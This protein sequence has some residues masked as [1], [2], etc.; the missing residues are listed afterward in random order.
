[1]NLRRALFLSLLMCA[2]YG[3][4]DD[5]DKKQDDC[6]DGKC[7]MP[8][9]DESCS[10]E[11]CGNDAIDGDEACDGN[12]FANGV[13][14][15]AA[16][17]ATKYESGNLKCTSCAIDTSDCV[18]KT[19]TDKCG[20]ET[21]DD[22]EACDGNKFANDVTSCAAYDATKYESGN[23]KCSSCAIDTSDC[24]EIRN[25]SASCGNDT[26]D[27]GEACDGNKFVNDKSACAD[28]DAKYISG[29]AKCVDCA[30]DLSECKEPTPECGDGI[31]NQDSEECDKNSFA[32]DKSM[33]SDI[34]DAYASGALKC[35]DE[36]K[37]IKDDCVQKPLD[38]PEGCG[39]KSL[40]ED[41]WCDGDQFMEGA[42]TC[43]AWIPGSKG[44]VSCMD[45][46]EV[47][48]G[49][50][51]APRCGDGVINQPD[52]FC[53]I[54]A[55]ADG[56]TWNCKDWSSI[57][58]DGKL[59]CNSK[60]VFDESACVQN[61]GNGKLDAGEWCDASASDP[62]DPA[63]NTCSK[64]LGD[65]KYKGTLQCN[66]CKVDTSKCYADETVDPFCGDGIIN[67]DDEKCDTNAFPN[68]SNKCE[69]Y[70]TIYSGG[71]LSCTKNCRLD[72]S[73][74]E[75]APV[76]LCGNGKIDEGEDCDNTT[77]PGGIIKCSKYDPKYESGKL[78][79][80]NLCHIDT[81]A[82][83][84]R[85]DPCGN[86]KLDEGELCDDKLFSNTNTLCSAWGNYA[87]GNV[88][89]TATCEISFA[90]CVAPSTEKEPK[91][92]DGIVNQDSEQCDY[93]DFPLGN[94]RCVN[95]KEMTGKNYVSGSVSCN[96]C[97]LD[98]SDCVEVKCGDGVIN[99]DDEWC[100]KD[101]FLGDASN[102]V[103]WGDYAGGKVSCNND[104]TLNLSA[105]VAKPSAKCGDGIINQ[106][107]EECDGSAFLF[108]ENTCNGWDSQ[109]I[110]GNVTCNTKT[111][112][113]EYG[114]CKTAADYCGNGKIDDNAGEWCDGTGDSAVFYD[115]LNSCD[116]YDANTKGALKC[117]NCVLDTSA[118]V[119]DGCESGAVRCD[120]N[121]LQM[122]DDHGNWY[123]MDKCSG[124][125][126]V[127][128]VNDKQDD[129]KCVANPNP[130]APVDWCDFQYL[131]P[132]TH[133]G[134]ARILFNDQIKA[135]DVEVAMFCTSDLDKPVLS[136]NEEIDANINASCDNCGNNTEFMTVKGAHGDLGKN[137]CTMIYLDGDNF[138][139]CK[140]ITDG[141]S[142][143]I[144]ITETTKLS[145]S[146]V[147]TFE[148][149]ATCADGSARCNGASY[150]ECEN[151]EWIPLDD[152]PTGKVCS[153]ADGLFACVDQLSSYDITETFDGVD[154]KVWNTASSYTNKVENINYG[155]AG[156]MTTISAVYN[157]STQT[158]GS[159]SLDN[160]YLAVRGNNGK[161]PATI[162]EEEGI[163]IVGLK[164]GVGT[165]EF[166]YIHWSE[167]DAVVTFTI[168]AGDFT[169]SVTL[170]KNDVTRHH[171]QKVI[172]KT[173]AKEITIF[174][175][176]AT[177]GRAF[178]DN[179]RWTSVY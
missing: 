52:E 61:C 66:N 169:D 59:K 157:P 115:W 5:S 29:N 108:N 168:T 138:F 177:S 116:K 53:D 34:S 137:Y 95:Y 37:L 100:D 74:C 11:L 144:L 40:D 148:S 141:A 142:D 43:N 65:E 19:S 153:I 1:M 134:Y 165:I 83:I 110:S 113:V 118:C 16:Y 44:T 26:L 91:C 140:P 45:N 117:N 174:A 63:A 2:A 86:G 87:S 57:Y 12:K 114:A 93:K 23:L 94:K 82:C 145:E 85:V 7:E 18:A 152:C 8:C 97:Q 104:C 112:K 175:D 88:T 120:G 72:V 146:D 70:S 167:Q 22:G 73:E 99:S 89:C 30:L 125:T 14:S 4:S 39:N 158:S 163:K 151:D 41:E 58:D 121:S 150:E 49:N 123:E 164:G 139:A 132:A 122:C 79:C 21:L 15:C 127:C 160:T 109:Y 25:V 9:E 6:A 178:I 27:D 92:G 170:A 76:V 171:Y 77:F 51:V 80:T 67:Q 133:V 38:K 10:S 35:S 101:A 166:D 62:F 20:N 154:G 105:C 55:I 129:G 176:T 162:H 69:K 106:D 111:C 107:D 36:C 84:E 96:A 42:D 124:D 71:T 48:T 126:P 46:C 155:N 13:T 54:D 143:P 102:C 64:Y 3:C 119:T 147:R 28:I 103:D 81:S 98:F 149:T 136:W 179:V 90:A 17:D 33:C 173:D 24:V 156:V 78:S 60:C 75:K 159:M 56:L 32:N 31:V 50:C 131:D 47:D 128:S 68:G 135:D 161:K 172:N 130:P